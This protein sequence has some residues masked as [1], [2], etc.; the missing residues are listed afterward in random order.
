MQ[1]VLEGKIKTPLIT[2]KTRFSLLG[3]RV[4]IKQPRRRYYTKINTG[5][6]MM[7]YSKISYL[8][9]LRVEDACKSRSKA[10]KKL[11]ELIQIEQI[12]E[13]L[14]EG[15]GQIDW[16]KGEITKDQKNTKK[17]RYRMKI[18]QGLPHNL[19]ESIRELIRYGLLHDF[20]NT[21][22]HTSK[23]YV[24]PYLEDVRLMD[25]LRKSHDK[26]NILLINTSN[27]YDR[28]S[29]SITRRSRSPTLYR[30]NWQSL[31]RKV[32]FHKLAKKIS[33]HSDNV[34]KLYTYI[35]NSREL[36]LLNESLDYGHSSL[37]LHLVLIA[38]LIVNDYLKGQLDAFDTKFTE[39]FRFRC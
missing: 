25:L 36:N 32:D 27:I 7:P 6:P 12:G 3:C 24:E 9:T 13:K 37:R 28:L 20:Y 4:N 1:L 15:C 34:F 33:E 21:S 8:G 10:I 38:N 30:Y 16:L 17:N 11:N 23:I 29:S 39:S 35:L 5:V 14:N 2:K 31:S 18:R 26:T 19:P 22:A